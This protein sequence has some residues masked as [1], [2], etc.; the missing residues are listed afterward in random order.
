M[1]DTIVRFNSSNASSNKPELVITGNSYKSGRIKLD[2]EKLNTKEQ[3]V[4]IYPNPLNQDILSIDLTGFE[5]LGDVNIRITTLLGQTVYNNSIQ[6]K[7]NIEISTS[8]LLTKGIYLVSVKSGQTISTT[9][10]IVQ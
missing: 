5:E 9:K 7:E 4:N 8:G 10:L 6:E 2:S 1:T 3:L